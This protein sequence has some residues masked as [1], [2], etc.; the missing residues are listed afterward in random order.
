MQS[1]QR[2]VFVALT[3]AL[4]QELA[5]TVNALNRLL[6]TYW[7]IQMTLCVISQIVLRVLSDVSERLVVPAAHPSLKQS[8]RHL[9]KSLSS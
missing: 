1:L 3:I 4:E 8:Y 6:E 7:I 5:E 2:H 9:K